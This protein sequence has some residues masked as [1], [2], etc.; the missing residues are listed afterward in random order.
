MITPTRESH[1]KR[2]AAVA[3]WQAIR[4][5]SGPFIAITAGELAARTRVTLAKLM[6]LMMFPDDPQK[7]RLYLASDVAAM[8]AAAPPANSATVGAKE[9]LRALGAAGHLL[10]GLGPEVDRR[11]HIGT[12]F[13]G[14]F[15]T[16]IGDQS[17]KLGEV[18]APLE[19]TWRSNR[20][21]ERHALRSRGCKQTGGRAFGQ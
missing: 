14:A 16:M 10:G 12:A 7:Q 20:P 2:R 4:L 1:S 3:A 17:A 21:M 9:A 15:I 18:L 13:A 6:V 19:K 8:I 5:S 11:R